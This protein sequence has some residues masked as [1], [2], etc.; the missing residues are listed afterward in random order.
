MEDKSND[1]TEVRGVDVTMLRT[2]DALFR[3]KSV[4][5]AAAR[6]FLSQPAVSACLKRL[7]FAFED[8]LFIRSKSGVE[9]TPRAI[10]LAPNV[11]AVLMELQRLMSLNQPFDPAKSDRILRIA[12]SDHLCRTLM[13]SMSKTLSGLGSKMR[14]SWSLA[15]YSKATEEL[16]RGDVDLV[17]IPR[18]TQVTGVQTT[19]LCE[20]SYVC[21]ARVGHPVLTTGLDLTKF[22]AYPHIVLG[23]SR[24]VLDDTVESLLMRIGRRRYVQVGVSSFSQMVDL[25]VETDQIAVFPHR[26]AL[27]YADVLG[28]A[29]LPFELPNYRLYACWHKRSESD[30]AAV[31]LR[32]EVLKMAAL[33]L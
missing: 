23:Q 17:L 15:D 7:R 22:C 24:S 2:F 9:P 8:E 21:V 33:M 27:R 29:P 1:Y 20:D 16:A 28:S 32:E 14:L 13:P 5:K 18:I 10:A 19:L 12:G 26:V 30:E 4:S 25:L 6:L 3:E 31:W 11:E